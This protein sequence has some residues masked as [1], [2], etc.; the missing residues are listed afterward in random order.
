[1]VFFPWPPGK[2]NNPLCS[3][4]LKPMDKMMR[5]IVHEIAGSFGLKSVSRGHGPSRYPSLYKTSHTPIYII[6]TTAL[7]KQDLNHIK[8]TQNMQ[9][10]TSKS[11]NAA[12][13]RNHRSRQKGAPNE[14]WRG[15]TPIGTVSSYRD[16]EVVGAAAPEL[17][18][19]NKGRAMLE[20]MGWSAG[21]AL[22]SINNRGILQ[23][24][25]HV[26]KTTKAGLK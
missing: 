19:G 12:D 18:V 24:V 9:T 10:T 14:A 22:G 25:V 2:C 3:I 5:R 23:P 26:I 1:M 16:G 17:G 7:I 6:S 13:R 20:K 15:H 11:L 21:T 8:F 4:S